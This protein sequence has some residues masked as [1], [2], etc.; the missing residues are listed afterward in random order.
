MIFL[1]DL[2]WRI[3]IFIITIISVFACKKDQYNYQAP[4]IEFIEQDDYINHD[5]EVMVGDTIK[6][7]LKASSL[8]EFPL[9][10]VHFVRLTSTDTISIDTAIYNQS[11]II[12]KKIIKSVADTEVWM[13]NTR[14]RNRI[15]SNTLILRLI[16]KEET[17]FNDIIY[18]PS[19]ILGFQNNPSIGSFYSLST[20]KEY[21]LNEAFEEQSKIHLAAFYDAAG[22][23]HVIA[24]PGANI[25]DGIFDGNEGIDHW[26]ILNTSRFVYSDITSEQFDNCHS[27][28]LLYQ[29]TFTFEIGKRKA[30]NLKINDIY[31]FISDQGNFGLFKVTQV[32]GSIEGSVEIEIKMK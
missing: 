5:L 30:K 24:S 32:S 18:I 20:R 28:S 13:I 9:L 11:I 14:D 12:E 26:D 15:S 22:D 17:N 8:S 3:A 21:F 19:V 25:P 23:E 1:K 31:A 7:K 10:Q 4:V 2:A 27:D 6:F 29:S 16:K